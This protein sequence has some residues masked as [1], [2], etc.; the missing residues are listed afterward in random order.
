MN[1]HTKLIQTET[2]LLWNKQIFAELPN[3]KSAIF[4]ILGRGVRRKNY[5]AMGPGLNLCLANF[6]KF[7]L[8]F[9]WISQSTVDCEKKI[10]L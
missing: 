4:M 1:Q 9:V 3:L 10:G 5:Q 7:L 2:E 6:M 8:N